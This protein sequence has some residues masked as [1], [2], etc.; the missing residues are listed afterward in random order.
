MWTK[1]FK[2]FDK[3]GGGSIDFGE[4]KCVLTGFGSAGDV[5]SFFEQVDTDGSGELDANEFSVMEGIVEIE[6]RFFFSILA[7]S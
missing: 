7:I 5:E 2:S 3:D 1:L 6:K 4:F